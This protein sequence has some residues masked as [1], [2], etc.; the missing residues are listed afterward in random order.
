[1]EHRREERDIENEGGEVVH[2]D[3]R[4]GNERKASSFWGECER[5]NR[6]S[7]GGGGEGESGNLREPLLL[8]MRSSIINNTSQI[9]V[10]GANV[11]PIESLD[12]EY[13]SFLLLH[14]FTCWNT[15]IS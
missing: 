6:I 1:M 12:Y 13:D 8:K 9:A 14:L 5:D 4:N 15:F 3:E 7:A 2:D 11:S 10:V